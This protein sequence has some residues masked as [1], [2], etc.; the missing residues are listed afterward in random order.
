MGN[1][2][3]GFEDGMLKILLILSAAFFIFV[4]LKNKIR[5][6]RR[7]DKL[8]D[9]LEDIRKRINKRFSKEID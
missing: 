3:Q 7:Q 2:N 8:R 6:F 4:I 9:D 1:Q 5:T